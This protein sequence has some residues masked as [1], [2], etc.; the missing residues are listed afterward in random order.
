MPVEQPVLE[1]ERER[2]RE[3]ECIYG[4]CPFIVR[5]ENEFYFA[6]TGKRHSASLPLYRI[7]KEMAQSLI[8]REEKKRGHFMLEDSRGK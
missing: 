2:E 5:Q 6:C 8:S 1:S 7:Q 4:L 3:R